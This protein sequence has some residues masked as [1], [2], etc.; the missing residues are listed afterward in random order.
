M[1]ACPLGASNAEADLGK[2]Q[3]LQLSRTTKLTLLQDWHRQLPSTPS[4]GSPEDFRFFVGCSPSAPI[5]ADEKLRPI[6]PNSVAGRGTWQRLHLSRTA[7]LTL[8]Q[9]MHR[10]LPSTPSTGAG[11]PHTKASLTRESP[12][13]PLL[14]WY[15]T[16]FCT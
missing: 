13:L 11:M 5:G 4:S 16:V 6:V 7:K 9:D 2:W 1:G 12:L 14:T 15:E 3:R 8:L 10:Q